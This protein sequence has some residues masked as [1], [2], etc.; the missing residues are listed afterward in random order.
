[1]PLPSPGFST[2]LSHFSV[3]PDT[4]TLL[5]RV[6]LWFTTLQTPIF[7]QP[8]FASWPRIQGRHTTD[9]AQIEVIH[10]AVGNAHM[11]KPKVPKFC[12][13][14]R[15]VHSQLS[16]FYSPPVPNFG[17][18]NIIP[19][20]HRPPIQ[21]VFLRVGIILLCENFKFWGALWVSPPGECRARKF[22]SRAFSRL[23]VGFGW[24]GLVGFR[25]KSSE[26]LK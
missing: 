3:W 7:C 12:D 19:G 25:P 22:H 4:T 2:Q 15:K 18:P 14:M 17:R 26:V 16:K 21:F 23:W 20:D 13:S 10:G 1:M 6:I 9:H 8:K 5:S 24:V 11:L